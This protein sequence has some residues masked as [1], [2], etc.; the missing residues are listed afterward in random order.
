MVIQL[1]RQ[2]L[3]HSRHSI[4]VCYMVHAGMNR[5][6]VLGQFFP[7]SLR[8][9]SS[10]LLPKGRHN[11][12]H[13]GILSAFILAIPADRLDHCVLLSTKHWQSQAT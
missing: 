13:D 8:L 11:H 12:Y 6:H 5:K 1:I 10:V 9:Y 4:N 7:P 2:T 3:S